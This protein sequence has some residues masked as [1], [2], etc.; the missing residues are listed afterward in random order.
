M[1]SSDNPKSKGLN[2]DNQILLTIENYRALT[3]SQVQLKYFHNMEYGLRKAQERL[4][5]L[6][7][8]GKL[9]R[10]KL[11]DEY[12]YYV[13]KQGL[14]KHLISLNWVRLFVETNKASW[15]KLH[16]FT[17]EDDYKVLRCDGFAAVKNTV[18]GQYKFT[19]IEMDRGTNEFDK[20]KKYN[21]LF[22]DGSYSSW[23]WVKL[24]DRFPLIMVVTNRPE[25]V[26]EYID[27]DNNAGLEFKIITLESIK[28]ELR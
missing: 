11:E 10:Q 2:R 13:T 14:L 20:V 3:T 15:E 27:K 7:K 8:A 23:W 28:E 18:T 5:K 9:Q 25:R 22:S 24:T 6:H 16:C 19:F 4:L 17:Y 1:K 21:K 12:C 26:Q